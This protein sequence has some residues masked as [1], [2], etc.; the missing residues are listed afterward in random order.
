MDKE[1]VK[2]CESM[3]EWKERNKQSDQMEF[4]ASFSKDEDGLIKISSNSGSFIYKLKPL[5]E[6]FSPESSENKEINRNLSYY[7][8][9]LYSIERAIQNIYLDNPELTDSSIILALENLALKPEMMSNDSVLKAINIEL[10][11]QL[12]VSDYSRNEVKKAIRKILNSA[13][14]HN[15]VG[16]MRGYLNFISENLP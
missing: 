13:I 1:F 9:L 14:R 12:S 8:P 16:G 5:N 15:K 2:K 11:L 4:L 7:M 6:L 10:R 3:S